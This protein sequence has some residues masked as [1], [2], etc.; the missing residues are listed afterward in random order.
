[1]LKRL[2]RRLA[3]RA[4]RHQ[5]RAIKARD[6]EPLMQS[7]PLSATILEIGGGYNPRFTKAAGYLHVHH[8]DHA[9]TAELKAKYKADPNVAHLVDRIQRIDFVFKGEPIETLIPPELRFDVV[10]GSHCLEHQVDLV[11]HLQSLEKLLKPGGRVIE[12]V[13]DLRRCFD[14]LRY[15][16][17]TADVLV[18]HLRRCTVH[19]GKQVFDAMSREVD[20]NPGRLPT[21]IEL[22]SV[23]F[24]QDL[25]KAYA[26]LLEAE[27]PARAY[28]DRHAWAFTPESLRL[29]LIELRLIGLT[30]LHA[31]FVSQSYENQF[32]AVLVASPAELT[33]ALTAELGAER[34]ALSKLLRIKA[35]T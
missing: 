10:Y 23:S 8:L 25:R 19:Q 12:V 16:S 9:S 28:I 7:V 26:A 11:E 2:V 1:M 20:C 13:P 3:K 17:V 33:P 24:T 29:M 4:D 5:T 15:P 35:S 32:C 22:N 30:T 34:L 14:L 31:T 21:D 27:L 18:A 6:I